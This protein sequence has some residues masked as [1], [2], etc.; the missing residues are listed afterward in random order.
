MT[1]NDQTSW[2]PEEPVGGFEI[3]NVEPKYNKHDR[4]GRE[5]LMLNSDSGAAVTALPVAEAGLPL[6]KQGELRVASG[7]SHS[8]LEQ[9]QDE[10]DGVRADRRGRFVDTSRK[11]PSHC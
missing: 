6:E 9:D 10:V 11:W 8:K 3:S 2:E 7:S 5:W 4:W 1:A